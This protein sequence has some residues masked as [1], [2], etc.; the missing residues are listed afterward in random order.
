MTS[1]ERVGNS[2]D[3]LGECPLWHGGEGALYWVDIRLPAI[4]RLDGASG[5]VDTWPMPGLIGSIAFAD[6]GRLLVAVAD[7]IELFNRR[8]GGF[9]T[10]ARLDLPPDHRFNDGRVDPAGRFWVGTMNNV[11]RAP[12]GTLYRLCA[13][14]GLQAVEGGLCIPNSLAWSPDGATMYFAD[15]LHHAIYAYGF[16]AAAGRMADRRD[17]AAI[18]APAFPDGS[19]VDEEGCLWNAEFNGSRIVRYRPSG[20]VDRVL[21]VPVARPTCCAFGGPDRDILYVTT[22]SQWMSE[23]DLA[24]QPLAGALL[25]CRPGM[26][27]LPEPLFRT[28]APTRT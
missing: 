11:T 22:A 18:A 26:R 28:T 2:R 6:D 16:G 12:E 17:F 10:L 8:T 13:G 7:R 15:S 24:A 27:G 5:Q 3:I 4:R 1:F 21:P 19:A 25:A 9:E 14:L 20:E 23:E